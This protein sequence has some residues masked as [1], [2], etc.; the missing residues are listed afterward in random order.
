MTTHTGSLRHGGLCAAVEDGISGRRVQV[1]TRD[2]GSGRDVAFA[3]IEW[4]LSER[5][6]LFT[7]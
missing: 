6:W 4:D 7:L 2:S 5:D 3:L 1:R